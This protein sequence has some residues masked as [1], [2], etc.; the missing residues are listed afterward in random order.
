MN[1]FILVAYALFSKY[2][3]LCFLQLYKGFFPL[4]LHVRDN[5]PIIIDT[6]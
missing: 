1:N 5:K 2:L 4:D 3:S 6:R